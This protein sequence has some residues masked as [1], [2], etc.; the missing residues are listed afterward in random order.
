MIHNLKT[1]I[2]VLCDGSPVLHISEFCH[3]DV[4]G[5]GV[6][7]ISETLERRCESVLAGERPQDIND[8]DMNYNQYPKGNSYA[9]FLGCVP[10]Y[11]H[12]A[13]AI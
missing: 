12:K 8:V 13:T 5:E 1:G 10:C 7:H 11:V 4:A 3:I 6:A 9:Q 2:R